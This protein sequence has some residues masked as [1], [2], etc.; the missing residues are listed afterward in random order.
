MANTKRKTEETT[1]RSPGKSK[2]V[3]PKR[4]APPIDNSYFERLFSELQEQAQVAATPQPV[5]EIKIPR[6]QEEAQSAPEIISQESPGGASLPHHVEPAAETPAVSKHDPDSQWPKQISANPDLMNTAGEFDSAIAIA[7]STPLVSRDTPSEDVSLTSIKEAA[8]VAYC[9]P[10]TSAHV[11][12][13]KLKYRLSKGEAN[14]L[15]YL[16]G[17]T[18]DKGVSECYIT[19]PKLAE[20]A[21]L[22]DRGCQLALKSL[23]IRGFVLR[24][25]EYDHLSRLG[26]KLKLN[27]YPA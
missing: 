20:A 23:Q 19:I 1:K 3:F 14:V 27:Y 18:Y 15:K 16:F 24:I 26:I 10:E 8:P 22:S 13:L 5:T 2:F 17:A 6:E 25:E 4:E 9:R 12:R 21:K 7:E 11:D